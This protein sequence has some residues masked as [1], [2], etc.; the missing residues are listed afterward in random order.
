MFIIKNREIIYSEKEYISTNTSSIM[1][2]NSYILNTSYEGK[3]ITNNYLLVVDLKVKSNYEKSKVYLADFTINIKKTTYTP[4][5]MYNKYLIDLGKGFSDELITQ[6]Y[7]NYLVVY[8]ISPKD[9]NKKITLAYNDGSKVSH[10]ELSPVKE[11]TKA[12]V[13]N[14]DITETLNFQDKLEGIS[15]KIN[16]YEIQDVYALKYRYCITSD[17][18]INSV[19]YIK[20][21][22]DK[23]YDKTIIKL[24]VEYQNSSELKASKFYNLLTTFGYIEYKIDNRIKRLKDIEQIVSTKL[25]EKNTLYIGVNKEIER[26]EEIKFVFNVRNRKYVYKI[27]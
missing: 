6:D 9:I 8:E 15:M 4:T 16:S 23:S 21:S 5:N 20:P 1:V 7:S 25:N 27:K 18:C 13:I 19:E 12:N 24:N 10:I 26:A 2:D 22:L 11:N 17:D 3:T 14:A